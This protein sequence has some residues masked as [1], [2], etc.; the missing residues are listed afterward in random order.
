M[1]ATT[2]TGS[3]FELRDAGNT[4][5]PAAVTY[6]AGTTTA[7]LTPNS[8]LAGSATYTATVKGGASGVKDAAGNALAADAGWT[9]STAAAGTCPCTIWPATTT[10]AVAANSDTAAVELGVKFRPNANGFITGLRFY[11]GSGNTGT[12]VGNLWSSGDESSDGDLCQ[13]D[14]DR[15]ATSGLRQS[16]SGD[17]QHGVC[18]LILCAGGAVCVQQQLLWRRG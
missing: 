15:L 11:K 6:N 5:V 12:H 7:T 13:R 9:F 16:G 2:V 18:G 1:N 8:A 17:R 4:L 3:T 14:S 10:P